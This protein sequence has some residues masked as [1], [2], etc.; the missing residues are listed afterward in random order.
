N[1]DT[2]NRITK[3]GKFLRAT[4]LDELPQLWNVCKGDMSLVG[5]RPPLPEHPCRYEDYSEFQKIRF[6]VKPGITGL[7]QVSVRNSVPWDGRIL[8]DVEYVNKFSV[9]LDIKIILKTLKK[10]F[11]RESIYTDNMN[12][13]DPKS[14]DSN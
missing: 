4:S 1:A 10:L 2:D 6:N 13:K 5:P 7:S 12:G 14:S 11:K 9:W 8:Y 3:I